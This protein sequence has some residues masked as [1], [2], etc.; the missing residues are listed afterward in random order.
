MGRPAVRASLRPL[1]LLA[2]TAVLALAAVACDGGGTEAFASKVSNVRPA[3][4]AGGGGGAGP[5]SEGSGP[6]GSGS[7]PSTDVA[8]EDKPY[9][10]AIAAAAADQ[11][12]SGLDPSAAVESMSRLAD[13]APA[14]LRDDY[15]TLKSVVGRLSSLDQ[16]DPVSIAKALELV[17]RPD[18]L[19]ASE[20]I[21]ADA[22]QRCGV[23]LSTGGLGES[24][25]S[26]GS[27]PGADDP[28]VTTPGGSARAG[29]GRIGL[30]DVEAV[31]T[32]NQGSSWAP[33]LTSTTILNSV[34]VTLTAEPSSGLTPDEGLQ[35]C[36]AVRAALV[37]LDDRVAV[38]I[39]D[40][41]RVVAA[42]TA[43]GECAPA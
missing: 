13:L 25:P 37:Q 15:R 26:G 1:S 30:Q 33:K 21:A 36:D 29:T 8:P 4:S 20:A 24:D 43:G 35:A 11:T 7:G 41:S 28:T 17:T 18:V 10:D 3:A 6:S 27:G 39:S 31:R 40:G 16:D 38:T 5:G 34:D 32:A 9:C 19:A 42:S 2:V 22:L 23:T 14:E 12:A